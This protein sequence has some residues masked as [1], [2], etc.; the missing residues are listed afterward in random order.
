MVLL[1]S[2][3]F[4]LQDFAK[5]A[6]NAKEAGFDGVEIHGANGYLIDQFLQSVSNVREDMYGGSL[7][8][9]FRFVGEVIDAVVS[10]R[11]RIV[12]LGSR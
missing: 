9:R 1:N 6:A 5:A 12:S 8:N 3:H 4:D 11:K 10:V 2:T 7:Q